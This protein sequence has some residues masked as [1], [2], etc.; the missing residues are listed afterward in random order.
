[1]YGV[2]R[3]VKIWIKRKEYVIFLASIKHLLSKK[4]TVVEKLALLALG[5]RV[6][7][8]KKDVSKIELWVT[9]KNPV[10]VVLSKNL[11]L[12]WIRLTVRRDSLLHF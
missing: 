3:E 4:F 12:I 1:M 10:L 7:C 8:G 11:N 6:F 2:G 9:N 5:E